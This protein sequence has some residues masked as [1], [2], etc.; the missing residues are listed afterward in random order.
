MKPTGEVE[1][2]EMIR[3][4]DG[5][6]CIQGGG[7][8][9]LSCAGDV[10]ETTGL[11]GVSLYDPGALTLVAGAGTPLAE[12]EALLA[13]E[14]QRLA[15]EPRRLN[16][17]LGTA[18]E[19]TLG[20][21]VAT[22]SAGPARIA[23][24]SCADHLL[25]VR[26]VTGAGEI[27]KNGGRVMKNVT[28]YDL[29]KLMAGSHGTLGVMSEVALKVLPR[30]ETEATLAISGQTPMQA[31][32]MMA[33]ALGSPFEVTGAVHIP[34]GDT[35]LRIEGFEASVTYRAGKLAEL[36]GVEIA[37]RDADSRTTWADL[38]D[39]GMFAN[40][41]ENLWRL[42]LKPTDA[43]DALARLQGGKALMDMA[44][45]EIWFEYP[46]GD[47]RDQLKGL[48]CDAQLVR[49]TGAERFQPQPAAL[50]KLQLGLR[51]R[52]DP[53]GVLNSGLMG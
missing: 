1:L 38:R 18:G 22:N 48:T 30:P 24:G 53:R 41:A 31:Q 43:P 3:A 28:G 32:A 8:R 26:F 45:G 36:T 49:G 9:G 47:M 20:G 15:F 6:L 29:V 16:G 39:L 23:L 51:A 21:I 5:P 25:G 13:K 40:G 46:E 37:S 4:A 10:I 44:G 7:T 27:V 50:A 33:R 35:L 19:T 34:G 17:L 11:S 2:S 42:R 14:G 52:F 12:V